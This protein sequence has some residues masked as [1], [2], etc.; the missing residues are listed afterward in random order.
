MT[1]EQNWVAAVEQ[2]RTAWF[3]AWNNA[4]PLGDYSFLF[5]PFLS[6]LEQHAMLSHFLSSRFLSKISTSHPTIFILA[7]FVSCDSK[8][9]QRATI[10]IC[11]VSIWGTISSQWPFETILHFSWVLPFLC[12]VLGLVKLPLSLSVS[13]A[14][15]LGYPR[16]PWAS[17]TGWFT[18][19]QWF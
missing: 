5:P 9:Y 14:L 15:F 1:S 11:F 12:R 2:N 13:L 3:V 18:R 10:Y 19:M 7:C 16:P 6:H 8:L 4:S 17:W